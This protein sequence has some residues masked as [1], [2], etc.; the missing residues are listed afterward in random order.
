MTA[1][2]ERDPAWVAHLAARESQRMAARRRREIEATTRAW[3]A[4]EA[5]LAH[6]KERAAIP[7]LTVLRDARVG[8]WRA[9][10]DAALGDWRARAD[11]A[12]TTMEMSA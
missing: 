6:L 4:A 11:A 12:I 3:L 2:D 5:H 10:L 1:Q 8:D 9:R 7:D